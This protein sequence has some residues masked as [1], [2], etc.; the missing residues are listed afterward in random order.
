MRSK[1]GRVKAWRQGAYAASRIQSGV[2]TLI[3]GLF[4]F[5]AITNDGVIGS[6]ILWVMAVTAG[7]CAWCDGQY[8]SKR[9]KRTRRLR[10]QACIQI[11][12]E[13]ERKD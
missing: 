1:T 9:E 3:C 13:I 4:A 2:G 5:A 7:W 8:E 12:D 10:R 6:V 11:A